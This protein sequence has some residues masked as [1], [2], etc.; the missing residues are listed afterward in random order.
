DRVSNDRHPVSTGCGTPR[1]AGRVAGLH[2]IAVGQRAHQ[3]RWQVL[4]ATRGDSVAETDSAAASSDPARWRWQ[5]TFT[6]GGKIRGLPEY[7]SP[8]R[9]AGQDVSWHDA[10]DER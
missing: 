10:S 3:L 1:D 5:R 6:P 4:S 7:H 8:G 9:Q 2:A